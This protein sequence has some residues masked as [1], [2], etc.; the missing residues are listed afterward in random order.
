MMQRALKVAKPDGYTIGLCGSHE[1]TYPPAESSEA[2]FSMKDFRFLASVADFPH[3]LVG[4][5]RNRLETLEAWR[6]YAKGKGSLS[7]GFSQPYERVVDRIGTE[8]GIKIVP[9]PFKGGAEMMQQIV[10]GNLDLGWSAGG[11]VP[12]EKA[13]LIK[14]YLA[15]T[16]TRLPDYPQVLTAREFGSSIAVESR[17]VIFGTSSL[18]PETVAEFKNAL[19]EVLADPSAKAAISTRNLISDSKTGKKLADALGIEA[20]NARTLLRQYGLCKGGRAS[21][22][23]PK[24]QLI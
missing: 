13:G 15:L 14:P 7:I 23:D 21:P 5:P 3:C 20:D 8:F 17:F 18:S 2:P 19:E 1:L 10:A 4:R 22:T 12:L 11:H 6:A 16:P 9:V 24:R